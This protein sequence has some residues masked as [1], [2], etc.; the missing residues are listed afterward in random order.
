[1]TTCTACGRT[2]KRP[3]VL[4]GGDPYGPSCAKT[5]RP[6]RDP[7]E[8]D[9]LTGVD[10]DGAVINARSR[11]KREIDASAARHIR[12]MRASWRAACAS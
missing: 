12:E 8:A 6:R 9:L 1:M 3:P 10:L 7:L 11:L 4:I 5:A 2:L